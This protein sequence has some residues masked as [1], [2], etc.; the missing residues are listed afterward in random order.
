MSI[1]RVIRMSKYDWANVP[2]WVNWIATDR[3]GEITY[4]SG[5]PYIS[6]R[7]W[8]I[9]EPEAKSESFYINDDA[10]PCWKESLEGRP[11]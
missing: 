4:F 2:E 5:K 10:C 3:N 9:D 8:I 6:R 7:Y 1:L 11:K